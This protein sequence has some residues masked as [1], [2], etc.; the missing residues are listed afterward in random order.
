MNLRKGV[1]RKFAVQ[2]RN[3]NDLVSQN[4]ILWHPYVSARIWR[5]WFSRDRQ[6]PTAIISAQFSFDTPERSFKPLPSASGHLDILPH[7]WRSFP[8]TWLRAVGRP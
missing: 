2:R 6:L 3:R 8:S 4:T 1:G 7:P 5:D